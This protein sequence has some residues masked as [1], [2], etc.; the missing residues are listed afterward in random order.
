MYSKIVQR[1]TTLVE[2]VIAGGVL[3]VGITF[4]AALQVYADQNAAVAAQRIEMEVEAQRC[5]AF[6]S[7]EGYAA[8]V[9]KFPGSLG[10]DG[11]TPL[12]VQE[13]TTTGS[14]KKVARRIYIRD[15]SGVGVWP[16][17]TDPTDPAYYTTGYASFLVTCEIG[18]TDQMQANQGF[19]PE[20]IISQSRYV[21]AIGN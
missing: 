12:I 16:P 13:G 8:I 10:N 19:S 20:S 21:A 9:A 1:G 18:H 6:V 3:A 15:T 4:A 11:S 5:L 14:G 17:P 7:D 2:T